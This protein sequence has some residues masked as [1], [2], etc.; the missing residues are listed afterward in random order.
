MLKNQIIEQS[1][2]PGNSDKSRFEK[3]I[4]QVFPTAQKVEPILPSHEINRSSP[5][6]D[7]QPFVVRK[8]SA[9]S[10]EPSEQSTVKKYS[11]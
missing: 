1:L 9:R 10:R 11:E 8:V 4:N 2:N 5:K 7:N 3:Y 6:L